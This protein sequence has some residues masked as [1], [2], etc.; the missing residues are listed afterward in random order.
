LREGTFETIVSNKTQ[1]NI[2]IQNVSSLR[3]ADGYI[4]YTPQITGISSVQVFNAAGQRIEVLFNGSTSLNNEVSLPFNK[5][6]GTYY[7][8]MTSKNKSETYV[9]GVQ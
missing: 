7:V 5:T 2:V 9:I 1:Q 6:P 4:K 8:H 3:Y